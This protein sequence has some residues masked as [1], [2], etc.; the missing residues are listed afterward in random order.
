M[1]AIII[2]DMLSPTCLVLLLFSILLMLYALDSDPNLLLEIR[3]SGIRNMDL[4][5]I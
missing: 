1:S 2:I 3:L 4:I 5:F